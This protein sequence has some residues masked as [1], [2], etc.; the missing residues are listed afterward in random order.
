MLSFLSP[1]LDHG[2]PLKQRLKQKEVETMQCEVRKM[3]TF[4]KILSTKKNLDHVNKILKVKRL[5]RQAKTGNNIVKK[6]RGRPRKQPL[7]MDPEPANQMPVLEKC[8]D[9]PGKKTLRTS[10][11][12]EPLEFS[13][14]DSIRDTIESVVHMAR[15]QPQQQQP[16]RG[17]KRWQKTSE[18]V[19][20]KRP[21]RCR[22]TKEEEMGALERNTGSSSLLQ[23]NY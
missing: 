11:L 4:S 22:G 3:C 2:S 9:L 13:N 7:L 12:P 14:H 20:A 21:R 5:Q 10:L 8:V 23:A 15:S 6:R 1:P 19:R 16:S 18:E 17:G